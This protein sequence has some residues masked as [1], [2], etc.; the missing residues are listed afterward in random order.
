MGAGT[1]TD[2]FI[3]DKALSRL[4]NSLSRRKDPVDLVLNGDT[5]DFLKCPYFEKGKKK[6]TRHIT[7]AISQAKLVLVYRAHKEVF[8]ALKKFLQKRKNKLYF[9]IGNHDQDLFYKEIRQDLRKILNSRGN[10]FFKLRYMQHQVYVEH[11]QQYDLF[12][13]I[14][15]KHKFLYYKG[16][17][18]LNLP[19]TSFG[20]ISHFLSMKEEHPF[21]ERIKPHPQLFSHHQPVSKK[22][23]SRAAEYVLKS[24]FYFPVR[25]YFDPT[26]AYPRMI[27]GE[28]YTRFKKNRWDVDEIVDIF[29]KKRKGILRNYKLAV[30]GHVHENY[31]EEKEGWVIVHPDTWRDEYIIDSKTKTLIPKTKKYVRVIVDKEGGLNWSVVKYPLIR[32][33]LYFADVV[34]EEKKYLQLAALEEGFSGLFLG[35]TIPSQDLVKETK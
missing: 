17:K 16:E 30:L 28:I 15:L 23:I 21:L 5:I 13:K 18:I 19:W 20:V 12:N 24:M 29:K 26:Y 2:D 35:D 31:L 8:E 34:K 4:I 9:I 25:Y 14:H 11:G 10:I 3:S 7:V 22:V 32:G 1:L 27:L 6:F 33:T